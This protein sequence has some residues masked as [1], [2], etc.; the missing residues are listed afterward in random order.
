MP[1]VGEIRYR[2]CTPGVPSILVVHVASDLIRISH[3]QDVDPLFSGT[4]SVFAQLRG[5]ESVFI[6]S[7]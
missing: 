3:Y 5:G 6:A 1:N 2:I 4:A 7:I